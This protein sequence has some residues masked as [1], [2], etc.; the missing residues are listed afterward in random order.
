[1][2][3]VVGKPVRGRFMSIC[4]C[5]YCRFDSHAGVSSIALKTCTANF[6]KRLRMKSDVDG[7]PCVREHTGTRYREIYKHV[8]KTAVIHCK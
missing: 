8:D 4:D 2:Q 3:L 1:M 7:I 5:I 6:V